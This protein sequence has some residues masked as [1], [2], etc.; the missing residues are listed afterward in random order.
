MDKAEII[1]SYIR[2][3]L[4]ADPDLQITNDISLFQDRLLDSLNLVTL[5]G[6][7]EKTFN[8]QIKSS[9]VSVENLDSVTNM[10]TF[11]DKKI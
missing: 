8:I 5:I 4:A 11:L 1:I 2:D 10:L 9:E 6:F 3:E 7:L